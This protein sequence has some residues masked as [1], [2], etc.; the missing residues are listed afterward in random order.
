MVVLS[1]CLIS[2]QWSIWQKKSLEE[3]LIQWMMFLTCIL[4]A[5]TFSLTSIIHT[6][7]KA[8]VV[9]ITINVLFV[10]IS[11]NGAFSA[12]GMVGIYNHKN[13]FGLIIS[14]CIFFLIFSE[15]GRRSKIDVIFICV[16]LGLLAL[17]FSKTSI[18]LLIFSSLCAYIITLIPKPFITRLSRDLLY[19]GLCILLL[20]FIMLVIFRFDVLNYLYYNMDEELMTGRG[21]LWLTMLLHA[22][23]NLVTGF[24]FNSVWGKQ[25]YSEIYFTD[26]FLY[27]PLWVE[28]LAAADGGYIDLILSIGLIGIFLFFNFLFYTFIN[29]HNFHPTAQFKW[30]LAIFIFI[31]IHNVTET[32]FLLST[33]V[34]W[35]MVILISCVTAQ[36]VNRYV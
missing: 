16:A 21:K 12:A 28:E 35:F 9:V 36:K 22:E 23:D 11:P 20:V 5:N 1:W 3:A 29:I 17:S 26:L 15:E 6:C 10:I 24:G 34:L 27:N 13:A 30:L 14:M 4:I 19:V 25:D 2:Y 31:V 8:A 7:K 18:V 33:N 32:T